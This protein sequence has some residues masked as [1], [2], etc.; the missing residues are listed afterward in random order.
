MCFKNTDSKNYYFFYG[1]ETI[2][3]LISVN[4]QKGEN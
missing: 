1:E 3:G 2:E 4:I